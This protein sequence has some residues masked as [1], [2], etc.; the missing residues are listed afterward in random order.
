MKPIAIAILT[1]AASI[2]NGAKA[3]VPVFAL[4]EYSRST[5]SADFTARTVAAGAGFYTSAADNFIDKIAYRHRQLN[6]EGPGF[7]TEGSADSLIASKVFGAIRADGEITR[8]RVD[9][10]GRRTLG[11]FQLAGQMPGA[12]NLEA[13]FEKDLVESAPSL[14]Q[15]ITYSAYTLAADKEI[16]PRFVLAGVAG[17]LDFSDNNQR[18]LFRLKANYVVVEDMGLSVYAKA[19]HYSDS[20]PGGLLYFSPDSYED[21]LGGIRIRRRVGEL[22]GMVSAY[23]EAGRQKANGVSSPARGWQ[24]RLESFPDKPWHYDVAIGL[25]TSADVGASQ[26][27][28]HGDYQYKYLRASVVYPFF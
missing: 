20:Q 6:Y 7:A 25:Q 27:S 24:V 9:S 23:F 11:A 18:D 3:D 16:T 13:R 12:V 2:A 1:L 28:V 21:Y 22:R 26:P 8:A 15:G 14:K 5:D 17:R 4:G 10:F 19:R